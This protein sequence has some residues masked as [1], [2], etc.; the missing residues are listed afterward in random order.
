MILFVLKCTAD[1]RF[2]AWF[3]NGDAY[4]TQA[5]AKAIACPVC[6]DTHITKAPMAR[7]LP[8]AGAPG[9]KPPGTAAHR[10]RRP[11]WRAAAA[12]LRPLP[13]HRRRRPCRRNCASGSRLR[14]CA[15]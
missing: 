10:R 3:R 2:E 8:K 14:L 12:G 11:R 5:A 9:R 13:R 4:E 6:G 1:H 7:A 15:N